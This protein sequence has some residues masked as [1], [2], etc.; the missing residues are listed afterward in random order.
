MVFTYENGLA[1][2]NYVTTGLDNGHE[3]EIVEGVRLELNF[4][5]YTRRGMET[6]NNM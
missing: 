1:K 4:L 2:W 6:L 3:V 5:G